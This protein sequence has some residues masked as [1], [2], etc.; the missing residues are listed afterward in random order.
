MSSLFLGLVVSDLPILALGKVAAALPADVDDQAATAATLGD[1]DGDDL[2][3]AGE[4]EAQKE[5]VL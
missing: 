2:P 1:G 3:G 5:Q 4:A